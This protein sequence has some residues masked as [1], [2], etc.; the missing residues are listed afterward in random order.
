MYRDFHQRDVTKFHVQLGVSLMFML[1]V[2][3]A[4][5]ITSYSN[6]NNLLIACPLLPV[7]TYVSINP[8]YY[9]TQSNTTRGL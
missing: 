4:A 5:L 1:I 9:I 3:V 6:H 7:V 8:D 2:F